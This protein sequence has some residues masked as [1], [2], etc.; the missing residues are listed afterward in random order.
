MNAAAQQTQDLRTSLICMWILYTYTQNEKYLCLQW[1]EDFLGSVTYLYIE[2][3]KCIS[4]FW[5]RSFPGGLLKKTKYSLEWTMAKPH[6]KIKMASVLHGWRNHLK[7]GSNIRHNIHFSV[8]WRHIKEQMFFQWFDLCTCH[9][10][11]IVKKIHSSIL[12][13]ALKINDF[14]HVLT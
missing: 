6:G 8:K 11:L 14:S 1:K 5:N 13:F 2:I 10:S 3:P 7:A 4:G 9:D 12:A